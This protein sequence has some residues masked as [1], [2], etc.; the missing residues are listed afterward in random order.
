MPGRNLPVPFTIVADDAFLMKEYIM[1]PYGRSDLYDINKRVYN[2]RLSRARRT[3]ENAFE[4]L[5]SRFRIFQKLIQ[6]SL[7]SR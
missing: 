6:H 3:V 2:Y 5:A 1:K 4:I 7:E